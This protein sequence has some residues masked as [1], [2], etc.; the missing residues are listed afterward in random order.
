MAQGEGGGVV[1][2]TRESHINGEKTHLDSENSLVDRSTLFLCVQP[3][4]SS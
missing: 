4:S 1:Q 2:P 3:F